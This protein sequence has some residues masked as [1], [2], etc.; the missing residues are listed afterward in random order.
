MCCCLGKACSTPG[1]SDINIRPKGPNTHLCIRHRVQTSL[2]HLKAVRASPP[3]LSMWDCKNISHIQVLVI[4]LFP[5][6]V[7]KLKMGPQV[8]GRRLIATHLDQSNYLPNQKHTENSINTIG[9]F[10][11]SSSLW[12]LWLFLGSQ[13]SSNGP[14][15]RDLGLQCELSL[16]LSRPFNSRFHFWDLRLPWCDNVLIFS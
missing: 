12:K 3:T 6:P 4:N 15:S 10:Q 16:A 9:L 7:V 11:G 8:G 5:P 13:G 2:T 1:R 14:H